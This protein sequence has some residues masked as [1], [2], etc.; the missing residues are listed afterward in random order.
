MCV[1]EC[2]FHLISVSTFAKPESPPQK[3]IFLVCPGVVTF[4]SG[5]I[6]C[7]SETRGVRVISLLHSLSSA[8]FPV[9]HP[10]SLCSMVSVSCLFVGLS[11]NWDGGSPFNC[12]IIECRVGKEPQGSSRP[13]PCNAMQES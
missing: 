5:G 10:P 7:Q 12:I 9:L 11:W 13:T 1:R 3:K 2:H 8:V 4:P 6:C